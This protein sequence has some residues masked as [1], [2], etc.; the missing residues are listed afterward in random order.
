MQTEQRQPTTGTPMLVPVPMIT[1]SAIT[2]D[3]VISAEL[4]AVASLDEWSSF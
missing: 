2:F 1:I 4:C 3:F